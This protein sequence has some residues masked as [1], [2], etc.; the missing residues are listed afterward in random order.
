M[1]NK[2]PRFEKYVFPLGNIDSPN[3]TNFTEQKRELWGQRLKE[4]KEDRHKRGGMYAGDELHPPSSKKA[5]GIII[6]DHHN[7]FDSDLEAFIGQCS[8]WNKAGF[9]VH[10]CSFVGKGSPIH[11]QLLALFED[12]NIQQVISS[13]LVVFDRQHLDKG[14]GVIVKQF[15]SE[16]PKT[17]IYFADDGVEN[18]KNISQVVN[19]KEAKNL[20]LVHYVAVPSTQKY[21]TPPYAKRINSFENLVSHIH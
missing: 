8:K 19:L 1:A 15:L 5:K 16:Y 10:V 2:Q 4:A 9:R 21:P 12:I 3:V 13:L 17:P 6:L 20:S 18:L 11:A 14:K 7:V